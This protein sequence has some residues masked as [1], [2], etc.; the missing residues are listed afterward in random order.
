MAMSLS[1]KAG[2][3]VRMKLTC[4]CVCRGTSFYCDRGEN[5]CPYTSGGDFLDFYGMSSANKVEL[6]MLLLLFLFNFVLQWRNFGILIGYVV[7]LRIITGLVL[8]YKKFQ[9][10]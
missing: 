7:F 8:T 2:S 5:P 6:M 1:L 3:F 10:L 9:T 4:V